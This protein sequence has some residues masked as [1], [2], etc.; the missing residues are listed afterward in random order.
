VHVVGGGGY[1]GS[2]SFRWRYILNSSIKNLFVV[3]VLVDWPRGIDVNVLSVD[4]N[5]FC[6][7]LGS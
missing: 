5:C 7:S 2:R 1:K 4:G 6:I 3:S